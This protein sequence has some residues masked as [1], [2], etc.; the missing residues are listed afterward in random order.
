MKVIEV[1]TCDDN[2]IGDLDKDGDVRKRNVVDDINDV[3]DDGG[4]VEEVLKSTKVLSVQ[5]VMMMV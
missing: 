3:G 4:G 1:M 2:D 5:I